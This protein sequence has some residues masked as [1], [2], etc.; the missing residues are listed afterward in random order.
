M[1]LKTLRLKGFKSFADE[2]VLNFNEQ[3]VGVVG[4]NGSGKSNIVDAIRWVLGEQKGKE[5]RLQSMG[6]VVFNGAKKRKAAKMAQVTIEFEND[7]GLL[8]TEFKDLSIS[9]ILYKSGESEYRLNGVKCR[10]KDI[11]NLF[12]DTGIGSNSYAII[13]LGMVDDIL[14]DKDKARRRMFEQAAGISKYKKRKRE[15]FLK[16]KSTSEDLERAEDLLFE[17]ENNLK[18]LEKQA[19]KARR[20]VTLKEKYKN[21]SIQLALYQTR[22]FKSEYKQIKDTIAGLQLQITEKEALL[23]KEEAKL[24]ERK[25]TTL[26]NE[27]E[28]S[29]AQRN[30]NTMMDEL[31]KLEGEK[32]MLSQRME[33]NRENSERIKQT[34]V[35]LSDKEKEMK[36]KL[37]SLIS[38][39]EEEK[40]KMEEA[41][42][43]KADAEAALSEKRVQFQAAQSALDERVKEKQALEAKR[44]EIE[45]QVAI[46]ANA[47]D[48]YRSEIERLTYE[49]EDKKK[50]LEELSIAL[51]AIDREENRLS[52]RI[53]ELEQSEADRTKRLEQLQAEILELNE[54]RAQNGRAIDSRQNEYNLLKSMVDQ[55]EGYPE[56]IKFLNKKWDGKAPLLSDVIDVPERY[57][58]AIEQYLKPHLNSYIVRDVAEALAAIEL[59]GEAQKGTAR[60]FVLSAVPTRIAPA[61]KPGWTPAMELVD[62]DEQ[63][64]PLFRYLLHGVFFVESM[65]QEEMIEGEDIVCIQAD[66]GT[67]RS[68]CS[69]SGGSTGLFSGKKIGRKKQLE[70]LEKEL[71]K[72]K[73]N[74]ERLEA[75]IAGKKQ[76][77]E[78]LKATDSGR[79]LKQLIR[80]FSEQNRRSA[81]M[82]AKTEHFRTDLKR[83]EKNL[84]EL[85][86]KI[87]SIDDSATGRQEE[88]SK[89]L[90]KIALL[91]A[92][93]NEQGGDVQQW[94]EALTEAST[95]F[96]ERNIAY[97]KLKNLLENYEKER[98][99]FEE[100]FQEMQQSSKE[101]QKQLQRNIEEHKAAQERLEEIE[102][103]LTEKYVEKQSLQSQ[104]KEKESTYYE[105]RNA[106]VD[107]ENQL[108]RMRKEVQEVHHVLVDYREKFNALKLELTAISERMNIEFGL[109]VDYLMKTELEEELDPETLAEEVGKL[110]KRLDNF[111]EVNPLAMQ[112]YDEMKARYD[113]ITA[114]RQ[115]ILDAKVSLETTIEEIEKKATILFLEAFGKVKEHFKSVFRSLFTE[116]DDCDL[117]L[118]QAED[119][120]NSE[121]EIIAKPKGK[122]PKT[123][124]Q[125][126]GGEKTLTA[127][128]LLFAL[129]LL[130]PA[131]FCIFDEVDAPLDDANILKFNKIINEFSKHSQ[132]VIVTH[133]KMTMAEVDVLYGVFMQENG[134]SAVSEVDFRKLSYSPLIEEV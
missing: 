33:F 45:K 113:T 16:L 101:Q 116:G 8:P 87:K 19:R 59:I 30:L 52:K 134:V 51:K 15:T 20:F 9:R 50:A 86:L 12:V 58:S 92:E 56:S 55:L 71:R 124:S 111:G 100:R 91:D 57:R 14:S 90:K 28:V 61:G 6:D 81:Q 34:I 129:Y 23:A 83:N 109:S 94:N 74:A 84:E 42:Q 26:E 64:M 85:H 54:Q 98:L 31:R 63:Y 7:K 77:L 103:S 18:M 112:A 17:I 125:L 93:I 11:T 53:G 1:R 110:K 44:F 107:H 79:E 119:P 121:I 131:P 72:F 43:L 95:R 41:E 133:N 46:Q 35:S 76:A 126:S 123:L 29:D 78:Q 47:R 132:F 114:Q 36:D 24:E 21:S 115:D 2:T 75:Q 130:K 117:I 97:F 120:L 13:E 104:L 62:T 68:V 10:L 96:N 32:S 25:R 67:I 38:R 66:S 105:I 108:K 69:L 22:S 128:A 102:R 99:Y 122:R 49:I 89:I 88:A 27:R 39:T 40:K 70:K 65:P 118:L 3:V 48:T 4:P 80:E 73:R 37:S 127:T 82:K 5:L 106:I 60:F